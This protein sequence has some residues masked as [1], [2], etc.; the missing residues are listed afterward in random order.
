VQKFYFE[1]SYLIKEVEGQLE[2]EPEKF[3]FCRSGGHAV[4]SYTSSGL[5][6][7][8][9][10]CWL[11]ATLTAAFVPEQSTK[12]TQGYTA[13]PLDTSLRALLLHIEAYW[14]GTER[15]VIF[16][17]VLERVRSK[18]KDTTKLE[19]LMYEFAY[20]PD[21]VFDKLPKIEYE[22]S[23]CTLIGHA[24]TTPLL[25]ITSAQ[26]VKDKLVDPMLK[27]YRK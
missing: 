11:P 24:N 10:R 17:G 16:S 20:N 7:R 9:V 21:Q 15:P 5:D 18:R 12:A 27:L 3:V 14:S 26:D 23:Y 22:D 2:K 8:Q 19:N 4:T 6:P 25:S 1:I 13:T